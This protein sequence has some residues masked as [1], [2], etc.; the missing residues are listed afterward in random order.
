M[1]NTALMII[2]MQK[3][4]VLRNGSAPVPTA[5]EIIPNVIRVLDHFRAESSPVFHIVREYR[6]DGSDVEITRMDGFLSKGKYAVPGTW[7]CEIIDELV[8]LEGEYRIVKNRFSGFMGT[9]L[10][11]ILRRK[12]IEKLVV[13]GIQYP[14]CIRATVYDAVA[15]G[16]EVC[17]V[18]DATGAATPEIAYANIL[19]MKNIGVNCQPFDQLS[20]AE[21]I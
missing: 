9:E 7:G 21:V 12:K 1:K 5:E 17:V 6:A 14:N 18:T 19:D 3:D 8:P 13:C 11:L 10:D 20:A 16:Y 4:F 15:L 2:D